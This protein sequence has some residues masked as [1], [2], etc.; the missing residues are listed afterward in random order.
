[1]KK[2]VKLSSSFSR[3]RSQNRSLAIRTEEFAAPAT[4]GLFRLWLLGVAVLL[5]TLL[6]GISAPVMGQAVNATLLGTVTDSSGAAVAEAKV[7]ATETKT[8]LSRSTT[9]ND[10]GNYAFAD[11]P[12]GQYEVATEKQ[13]F[14]KVVRSAVDVVV[15]T[16]TRVNLT[17]DRKS[18]RLN[19]SHDQISYAVFCLK[20]KKKQQNIS[21]SVILN[22]K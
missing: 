4:R 21:I 16:D 3:I 11:L 1:M 18:T 2:L 7:T 12:P 15:N 20:K 10:S 17:L 5:G 19:S 9:T 13:G 6:A 8:G 22:N 14:K